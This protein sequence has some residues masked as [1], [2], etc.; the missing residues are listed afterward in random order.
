MTIKAHGILAPSRSASMPVKWQFKPKHYPH[1][2]AIMSEAQ[3]KALVSNPSSVASH[4]FFPFLFYNQRWTKFSEKGQKGDVKERPIRY[5]ARADSYIFSYY[6][7]LL[8]QLYEAELIRS[9]LQNTVLAYRRV[10]DAS[11]KGKCNIHFANEAFQSIRELGD[12]CAIA[13]DISSFFESL[14]HSVLKKQWCHLLK[15]S[16]LPRDHFR[17]F[18]AITSYSVVS[19]DE[20]YERLGYIGNKYVSKT[21]LPIKGYLIDRNKVPTRLCTGAEFREKVAGGN[22]D[23]SLIQRNWKPYGIP[24]GSPISDLLANFYLLDF[25]RAVKEKVA[26][27]G[28][29]YYRYSDDILII[30]PV[31]SA[32]A[33]DLE[34]W[35]R[36]EISSHGSKLKI[37]PEKSAIFHYSVVTGDQI[38][39]RIVGEQGANGLEYLGFRYDGKSIFLR[40]STLSSF[41]RKTT[42]SA[43]RLAIVLKKKYPTMSPDD[44]LKTINLSKFLQRYGRVKDFEEKAIDVK[45]WTFWTYAT[46]AA[47]IMAPLGLPIYRQLRNYRRI[48]RSKVKKALDS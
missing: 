47:A 46:R 24:Q 21:G 45:N 1:F 4:K 3:A 38:W 44:I 2:D 36:S 28:G 23:R 12:C 8:S 48:M 32:D 25:D 26:A 19:K 35:V 22:G 13:L 18:K 5:S 30:A 15:S 11:G 39:K 14:D 17:V 33:C 40:D 16:Q 20:L 27:L 29:E 7:H 42:S 34:Q 37:K 43:K 10:T 31:S 6:R 41:H 9:G